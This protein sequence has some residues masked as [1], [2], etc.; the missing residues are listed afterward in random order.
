MINFLLGFNASG[1]KTECE[2]FFNSGICEGCK[3]CLRG[4][5]MVLFITGK[6][7]RNCFYCPLSKKRKNIDKI[8]AN[9]KECKTLSEVIKEAEKSG[10]RGCGITGGDPLLKM[11][12]TLKYASALKKRFKDFH[13]HIYLS[14]LLV[15]KEKLK[16]LSEFVDEVRFHP[17]L[18]G[19]LKKEK[20]KIK[21]AKEFFDKK[22]IGIEVPVFPGREKEILLLLKEISKE[23]GFVNL[24]E[25]EIGESN[26]DLFSIKYDLNEDGYTVKGSLETGKKL[27]K[28]ISKINPKLKAHLCTARTKNWYQLRNRLK[29]YE[30][31]PF[32]K[33]TYEGTVLYFVTKIK[34]KKDILKVEKKFGKNNCFYDSV[35]ER[36]ILNSAKIS[37]FVK[38]FEIYL[39]E[40]YP[41][42][43][44]DEVEIEKVSSVKKL[45]E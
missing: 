3:R 4:R 6:C 8:W 34:N 39:V 27:L 45:T 18:L 44:R 24:N 30:I 42:H 17:N 43:D 29:H 33:R 22:N 7:S 12:R 10:A 32:G 35:K 28:K 9:E 41:S 19:D 15:T 21:L 13:I 2:S 37:S 20:F 36:M 40:E 1:K 23:I 38:D 11:E 5:K 14:T 26:E 25:L 16:R 31:L